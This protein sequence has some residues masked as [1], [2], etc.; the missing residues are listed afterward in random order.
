MFSE[1]RMQGTDKRA[2]YASPWHE[3]RQYLY[4]PRM[5][6]PEVIIGGAYN[7]CFEKIEIHL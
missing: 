5:A 6:N 2:G 3:V 4:C 7:Q 1:A